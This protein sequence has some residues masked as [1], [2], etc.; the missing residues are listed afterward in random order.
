MTFA[1]K[2]TPGDYWRILDLGHFEGN[3]DLF[4]IDFPTTSH[5]NGYVL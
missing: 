4:Y 2:H 5:L 3:G 1:V